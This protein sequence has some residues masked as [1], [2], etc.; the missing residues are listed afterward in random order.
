MSL[1]PVKPVIINHN[2]AS[3][4]VE[5]SIAL[6]NNIMDLQIRLRDVTKV[7]KVSFTALQS[8]VTYFTLDTNHPFLKFE[9]VLMSG[10]TI[11]AQATSDNVVIELIALV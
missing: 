1:R 6:P 9:D 10:V 3:T 11:Y 4:G 7:A 5:E 2:L 8:G